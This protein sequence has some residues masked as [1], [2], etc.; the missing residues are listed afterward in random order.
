[1]IFVI[2]KDYDG[3]NIN[4][5]EEE[6]AKKADEK[7]ADILSLSGNGE[8]LLMIIDGKRLDYDVVETVKAVRIKL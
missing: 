8:R 6:D 4:E 7:I 2:W 3:T 1:M 5:F